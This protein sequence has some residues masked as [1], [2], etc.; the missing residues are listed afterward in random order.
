MEHF[1]KGVAEFHFKIG[2]IRDG[3]ERYLLVVLQV[4]RLFEYFDEMASHCFA[5]FVAYAEGFNEIKSIVECKFIE[6]IWLLDS[7]S[8]SI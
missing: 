6:L 5:L 8:D 2:K 7:D 1:L 4:I 3:E